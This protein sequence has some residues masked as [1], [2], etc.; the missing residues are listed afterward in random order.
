MIQPIADQ[1]TIN[2][3]TIFTKILITEM[4]VPIRG[5]SDPFIVLRGAVVTMRLSV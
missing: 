4:I 3:E 2:T 5:Y 1:S